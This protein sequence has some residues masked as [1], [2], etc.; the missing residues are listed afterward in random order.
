[1]FSV[2]E[3]VDGEG[4]L[5]LDSMDASLRADCIESQSMDHLFTSLLVLGPISISLERAH[6]TRLKSWLSNSE[7]PS[8]VDRTIALEHG[9]VLRSRYVLPYGPRI[10]LSL[11]SNSN[12]NSE[13]YF[14]FHFF[15]SLPHLNLFDFPL[16]KCQVGSYLFLKSPT[17]DS[18]Y[19]SCLILQFQLQ[20]D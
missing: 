6:S 14:I 4:L 18:A 8:Q 2:V 3:S 9:N 10:I 7:M 5:L 15:S 19:Q 16:R 11:D 13:S 12:T 17:A 20:D 1:M